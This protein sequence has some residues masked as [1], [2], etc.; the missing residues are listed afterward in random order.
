M[1][2]GTLVCVEGPS[3]YVCEETMVH[4][5]RDHGTCVKGPWYMCQGTMVHVSRDHGT[6]AKGPWYVCEG[7]MVHV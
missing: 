5:S 4:V 2:E 1:C 7:T 6:C 3:R